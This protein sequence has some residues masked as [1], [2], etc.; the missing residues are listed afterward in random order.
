MDPRR[1]S[2]SLPWCKGLN[3]GLLVAREEPG[4]SGI[5]AHGAKVRVAVRQTQI[6]EAESDGLA[7]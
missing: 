6:P 2:A 3:V 5:A 4:V 1:R 7:E